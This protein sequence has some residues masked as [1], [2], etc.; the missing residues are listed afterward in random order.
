VLSRGQLQRAWRQ[1]SVPVPQDSHHG[2]STTFRRISPILV[3]SDSWQA[4]HIKDLIFAG[5][6]I[7][8]ITFQRGSTSLSRELPGLEF[9]SSLSSR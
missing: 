8:Q 4:L 5:T 1:S 9:C 6:R 7:D 2:E 3:G